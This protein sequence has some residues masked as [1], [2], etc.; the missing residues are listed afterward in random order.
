M[1]DVGRPTE[2]TNEVLEKIKQGILDGRTLKD[3]AQQSQINEGTLYQWSSTNYLNLAD[4]VE[5]W[6]RDRKLILADITSDAIQTASH[7]DEKGKIDKEL[8]KIKQK[9]AEFIRETLG[10]DKGY[11]KRSELTGKEG[12]AVEVKNTNETLD[13]LVLQLVEANKQNYATIKIGQGISSEQK[14]DTVS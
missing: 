4:K 13:N 5:G 6:K 3:I 11:S 14:S 9:E 10:K 12:G 1:S 8:L 7:F 2:L